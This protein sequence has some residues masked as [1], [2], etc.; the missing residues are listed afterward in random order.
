MVNDAEKGDILQNC[1]MKIVEV[2]GKPHLCL[3]ADRDIDRGEELRFDY[4]VSNL[5]WR[6]VRTYDS[7]KAYHCCVIQYDAS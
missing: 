2:D 1:V 3:F 6:Q 5:P 7:Y 4:G